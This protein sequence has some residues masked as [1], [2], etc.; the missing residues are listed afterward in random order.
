MKTKL[1]C[2]RTLCSLD[3]TAVDFKVRAD[4]H[5]VPCVSPQLCTFSQNTGILPFILLW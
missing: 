5:M 1:L 3:Y 2:M 4:L